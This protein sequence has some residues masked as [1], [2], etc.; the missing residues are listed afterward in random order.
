MVIQSAYATSYKIND[1]GTPGVTSEAAG[2]NNSGAIVGSNTHTS[3]F[4]HACIWE[5]NNSEPIDLGTLTGGSFSNAIAINDNG[6]I[7]GSSYTSSGNCHACIWENSSSAP[8]DLGALTGGIFSFT[9]AI[10]NNGQIVGYSNNAGINH[11]CFWENGNTA[12]IDLG[13]L[14]G[15]ASSSAY[16][17]NNNGQI[18]GCSIDALGYQHACIWE[19][20]N[21]VPIDLGTLPVVRANNYA[22]AIND[23]GQIVGFICN[24]TMC[25]A[26]LWTPTSSTPNINWNPSNLTYGSPLSS[27][28]LNA[29]ILDPI[30]GTDVSNQGTFSYTA[31]GT[32]ISS[33]TI[34]SAGQ[35]VLNVSWTPSQGSN[36]DPATMSAQI[37][38]NQATPTITIQSS[39]L[40]YG[41]PLGSSQ[42][43]AT[44]PVQGTFSYTLPDGT[45]ALN[46]VLSAGTQ[47][48]NAVFIPEDILNYTIATATA[49]ITVN[50]AIPTIVWSNPANITNGTALSST[51]LNAVFKGVD[52]NT[53]VGIPT[54]TPAAGT[55]LNAGM[56]QPLS[57]SFV[58][59]DGTNYTTAKM[60]VYINVLT[61]SQATQ[62]I[63]TD[64]HN[65]VT[66]GVINGGQGNSLTVKLNNAIAKLNSGKTKQ[67][68]SELNAFINE[69]NS[70]ISTGVLSP[71]QG[72]LLISE[73]NVIINS[74]K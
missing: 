21:S 3:Y 30:S 44:C 24:A 13:T 64:V 50:P 6:E 31:D 68:T 8:V 63:T 39:I 2:I 66:S 32:P 53:L 61:L 16:C 28:Q 33:G 29:T 14:P 38:V 43:D 23:N 36:Y 56:N 9:S 40:T 41:T 52:G 18:A 10:N 55:Y 22:D 27:N 45:P 54:Y 65:L 1:L 12:P 71:A 57:A 59:N 69:V 60:T 19:S 46:A 11:A 5:D 20:S 26:V 35:H 34:L 47:T 70:D 73:A 58:P 67:A 4:S 49:T 42:L 62:Q 72:Q 15:E 25:H 74:I 37:T 48:I 51:Q 7:A 17:I